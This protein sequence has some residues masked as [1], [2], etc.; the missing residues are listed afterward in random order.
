MSF[1]IA[2]LGVSFLLILMIAQFLFYI[3]GTVVTN[4]CSIA[5]TFPLHKDSRSPQ[6][7][8]DS[9]STNAI[10]RRAVFSTASIISLLVRPAQRTT[11]VCQCCLLQANCFST[12]LPHLA[13]P[14]GPPILLDLSV[15]LHLV[16]FKRAPFGRETMYLQYANRSIAN[17]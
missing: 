16:C 11:A 4:A 2:S 13:D 14:N 1:S 15:S 9:F 3:T 6:S 10:M 7:S 17:S 8:S 12:S 5:R